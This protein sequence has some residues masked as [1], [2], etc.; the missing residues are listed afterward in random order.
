MKA[1]E[2]LT[3]EQQEMLVSAIKKAEKNTSGE[4]RIHIDETCKGDPMKQAGKIFGYLGMDR[5]AQRNGVLIYLACKSKV[6]CIIG[7]AGID[8]A[9]PAGFWNDVKDIMAGYF[10]NGEFARGLERAVLAVGEK[11]RHYFPYMEDD[12][13]EQPDEISFGST[14]AKKGP[15]NTSHA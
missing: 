7:D 10:R 5:T 14:A 11:L 8:K 15:D 3:R 2:F 6:F 1:S 13:N 12:I 9:V 4:I